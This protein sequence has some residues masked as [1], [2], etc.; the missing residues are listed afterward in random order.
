MFGLNIF[1]IRWVSVQI[2]PGLSWMIKTESREWLQTGY[3]IEAYDPD[4]KLRDQTGRVESDQ[5]VLVAWPFA[6]LSS[7]ERL[8]RSCACLGKGWQRFRMERCRS[9]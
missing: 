5:S 3:E 1:V 8:S 4:G 9:S 2:A 6:P 7:R